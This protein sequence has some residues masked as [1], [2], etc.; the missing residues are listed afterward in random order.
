[1]RRTDTGE[2]II[3]TI[4]FSETPPITET[5][6]SEEKIERLAELIC[7]SGDEPETKSA[8]LL[9]L[10]VTLKN[11]PHPK[12]LANAAKHLGLHSLRRIQPSRHRGHERRDTRKQIIRKRPPRTLIHLTACNR[13]PTTGCSK[14]PHA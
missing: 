14:T 11:A 1:V 7:R 10:M 12:A 13:I 4:D 3:D 8:A 6:S 2:S 5:D 9:V